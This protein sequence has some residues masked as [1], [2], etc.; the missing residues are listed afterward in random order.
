MPR[1]PQRPGWTGAGPERPGGGRNRGLYDR[2]ARMRESR[3]HSARVR[4]SSRWLSRFWLALAKCLG[5]QAEGSCTEGQGGSRR[6][7]LSSGSVVGQRMAVSFGIKLH[8]GLVNGAV[9]VIRTGERLMSE[10]M[11]LQV[12]P[13]PFDVVQLWGVRWQPL[14]REPVG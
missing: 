8:D 13:D 7:S 12:A 5:D 4:S 11:P 9:E 2:W 6:T 10:V 3:C 14:D 1:R